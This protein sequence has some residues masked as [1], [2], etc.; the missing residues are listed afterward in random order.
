VVVGELEILVEMINMSRIE[1]EKAQSSKLDKAV[2][3]MREEMTI[4]N[5]SKTH[6]MNGNI[7]KSI[8][9]ATESMTARLM[10]ESTYLN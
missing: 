10:K 8:S 3:K 4:L 6:E 1:T 9:K 5:N 2:E 7:E